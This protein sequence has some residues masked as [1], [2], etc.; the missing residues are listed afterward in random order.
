MKK[1][2]NNLDENLVT[3]PS[4]KNFPVESGHKDD[5]HFEGGNDP[6]EDLLEEIEQMELVFK[7]K[8]NAGDQQQVSDF[9]FDPGLEILGHRVFPPKATLHKKIS[10]LEKDPKYIGSRSDID[11]V[12]AVM[13]TRITELSECQKR[14]RFYVNEIKLNQH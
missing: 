2:L 5:L 10:V 9:D 6:I 11:H 13:R 12:I 8:I 7:N 1:E 4:A 3:F 14:M